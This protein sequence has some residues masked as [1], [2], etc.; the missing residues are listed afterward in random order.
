MDLDDGF[1]A[2]NPYHSVAMIYAGF[3]CERCGEYSSGGAA[4][5]GGQTPY[6]IMAEVV[7]CA[8]WLVEDRDPA[9]YDY[10]VLCPKGAVGRP[11]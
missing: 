3:L 8:G 7:Q 10:S 5:A 6:R 9:C 4:S 1:D 11:G 2:D